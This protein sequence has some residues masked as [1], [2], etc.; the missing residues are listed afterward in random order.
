[1]WKTTEE[2]ALARRLVRS[3]DGGVLSTMSV[4]LPGYPFGSVTPYAMG[5]D[6]RIAV[7]VSGIAQ[8]TR[9]MR[10]DPKVCLT[11]AE[12]PGGENRQAVGRA[13]VIG[14][15]SE[16]PASEAD[17]VAERYFGFFPEAREYAGTHDFSF[18]RIEPRRVR[19]IGGFGRIFWVEP[20]DWSVPAPEW[21]SAERAIVEHM[22]EDHA[23]SL[24]AIAAAHGAAQVGAAELVALDV[25]GFHVRADASLLYVPFPAPCTT[26]DEVRAAMIELAR[27][28]VAR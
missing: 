6:G 21:T 4:E 26:T 16:V 28:A 11:V 15:A 27:S 23:E 7:Y 2:A 1:M 8:H 5:R 10:A 25:E 22:N 24:R 19:Y 17:A 9:N 18:Y 20:E 12:E 13:T 14:D 3:T